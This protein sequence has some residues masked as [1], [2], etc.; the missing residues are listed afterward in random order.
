MNRLEIVNNRVLHYVPFSHSTKCGH[1]G[2]GNHIYFK[3]TVIA[4]KKYNTQAAGSYLSSVTV[5]P[6]GMLRPLLIHM[7]SAISY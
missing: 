7:V 4:L 2:A 5:T 1:H 6:H 3:V